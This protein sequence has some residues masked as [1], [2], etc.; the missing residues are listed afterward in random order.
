MG[1][2]M[3][4]CQEQEEH[5]NQPT[6]SATLE[7]LAAGEAQQDAPVFV[8]LASLCYKSLF[9]NAVCF[10]CIIQYCIPLNTP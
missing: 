2:K 10:A 7:V 1:G 3:T 6:L 5:I 9:S 4:D 8:F